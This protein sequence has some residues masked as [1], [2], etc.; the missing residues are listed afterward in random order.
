MANF[1]RRKKSR[2]EIKQEIGTLSRKDLCS[3]TASK[4]RKRIQVDLIAV[5]IEITSLEE[6]RRESLDE[7]RR[8][9]QELIGPALK[10]LEQVS[11]LKNPETRTK[12]HAVES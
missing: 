5:D 12:L 9:V 4:C 10:L 2:L 1:F 11:L 8:Q 6:K 7:H 3:E